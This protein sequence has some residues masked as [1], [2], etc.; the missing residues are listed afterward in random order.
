MALMEGLRLEGYLDKQSK[1]A[2]FT[3]WQRRYCVLDSRVGILKYYRNR[4][5]FN[6]NG[7][8]RGDVKLHL[9]RRGA[10]PAASSS[11]TNYCFSVDSQSVRDGKMADREYFFQT[12]SVLMRDRYVFKA[13]WVIT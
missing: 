9:S 4:E 13:L 5:A 7:Q 12:P 11:R 1:F 6:N 3:R 10:Q 2:G 8:P